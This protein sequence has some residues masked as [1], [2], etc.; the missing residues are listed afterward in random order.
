MVNIGQ[1]NRLE[2]VE[3]LKQHYLLEGGRYGDIPIAKQDVPQGTKVGQ[4]IDAFVFIDD[5]GYLA[6]S[7]QQSVAQVGQFA[8]LKVLSVTPEGAWLDWGIE[9]SL[10]L[11]RKEQQQPVERDRYCLVRLCFE[12][13]KGIYATTYLNNFL[14]NECT[15]FKQGDKVSILI[16]SPTELGFRVIVNHRYWGALYANE[17]FQQVYK[18]QI[19]E[20]YVKRLREDKR[21][22]L[23]LQPLG[24]AK[25]T[26]ITDDI[27]QR[28]KQQKGYLMLSDKSSPD[29]IYAAFGVSKKVFKQAIGTLFKQ[30]QIIIEEQGIRLANRKI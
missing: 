22:D 28:L 3:Q 1:V 20:A 17:V 26:G 2:V 25:V 5:E 23:S 27:L 8:S 9:P 14:Q 19:L 15:E 18:G 6:A 30:R 11:P 10:F 7:S 24:F 13:R 21:L 16:A 4:S 12:E 29:E